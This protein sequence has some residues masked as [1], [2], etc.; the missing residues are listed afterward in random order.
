MILMSTYHT[1]Q[2]PF[3][4]VY[5]HGLVRDEKNRKMSKSL[6]NTI[7]PLDM[8]AKYG[9]DATRLSLIIGAAPGNDVPLSENKIKGYS[10]FANKVWNV[11]RFVLTNI[12]DADW[13]RKPILTE[14]DNEIL[15]TLRKTI[16]DVTD[17]IELFNLY[18]AGEKAYHYIWHELADIVLEESKPIIN[19]IN[20]EDKYARQYVLKECL[21]SSLKMLHPF[22]PF[23]T[24]TIW[25]NSPAEIKDRELLMV[26]KWPTQ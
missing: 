26:S 20:D 18:L 2:I 1:G 22:M 4:Q 10:K 16:A 6:G 15:T 14:R 23:V 13:E 19:G 25:Q 9:A 7:D 21:V 5:L 12:A 11:S 24:E 8:I 3:K 17:E